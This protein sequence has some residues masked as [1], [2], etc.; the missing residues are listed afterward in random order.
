VEELVQLNRE[1][2]RALGREGKDLVFSP[3]RCVQAHRAR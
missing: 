3:N 1:A 2:L